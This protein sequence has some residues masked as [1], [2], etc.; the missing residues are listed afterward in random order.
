MMVGTTESTCVTSPTS[1]I[2]LLGLEACT[3]YH[4]SVTSVSTFGVE[5]TELKFDTNTDEAGE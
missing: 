2:T 1:N 4:I 3:L 5:S